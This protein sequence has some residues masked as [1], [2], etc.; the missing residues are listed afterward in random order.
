MSNGFEIDQNDVVKTS[1]QGSI[2][3]EFVDG[4]T[5]SLG[6]FSTFSIPEYGYDAKVSS[7]A[8]LSFSRGVFLVATGQIG[9]LS[10]QKFKIKLKNATIGIRGTTILGETSSKKDFVACEDGAITVSNKQ[11]SVDLLAGQSTEVKPSSAPSKPAVTTVKD[12]GV[13]MDSFS[14]T[15]ESKSSGGSNVSGQISNRADVKNTTN[16]AI[17]KDNK[18]TVGSI[19][20]E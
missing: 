9:K 12:K 11:G 6:K 7:K 19:I 3:L 2:R 18:A 17:G 4:T 5:V 1:K 10:P 13:L 14:P 15:R 20:I 8:Q 16:I